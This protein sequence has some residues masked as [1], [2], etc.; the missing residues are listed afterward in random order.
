ME[1]SYVNFHME[2]L[3]YLIRES[4]RHL[5]RVAHEVLSVKAANSSL[6]D[7]ACSFILAKVLELMVA[8]ISDSSVNI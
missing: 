6:E 3:N 8:G 5:M 2:I 7:I 4:K 1:I